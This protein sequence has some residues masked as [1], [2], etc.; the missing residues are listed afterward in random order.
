M[1][2]C[3]ATIQK[4]TSSARRYALLPLMLGMIAGNCYAPEAQATPTGGVVSHGEATIEAISDNTTHITQNSQSAIIDWQ[5]FDLSTSDLVHFDQPSASAAVLNRIHDTNPSQI[6]GAIEGNGQVFLINP[7]GILIGAGAEV[8]VGSLFLSTMDISDDD[9]MQGNYQ[10]S[11]QGE[12]HGSIINQGVIEASTGG[13]VAMVGNTV[14]N[15]GLIM[16]DVGSVHLLAGNAITVDFDGDGL[17]QFQIDEGVLSN[18]TSAEAAV[19]NTGIIMAPGGQVVMSAEVASSIFTHAVNNSGIIEAENVNNQAGRI[20]LEGYGA[21]IVNSGTL[22]VDGILGNAG[23]I[24]M[25]SDAATEVVAYA[26]MSARSIGEDV[27]G[28][29]HILGDE[30]ALFDHVLLDAS[31]QHG[32]GEILIGGD[33]QGQ[34]EVPN[35]QYTYVDVDVDIKADAIYAGN[36]GKVIVWADDS[37]YIHGNIYAQGGS[38]AGNGGF[39]ETSGKQYLAVSKTPLLT[40]AHGTGGTWLLDPNNIEI[41][42]GGGNTNINAAHPFVSTDDTAQL[43]VDLILSALTGG[44]TVT[45]TTG[46]GGADSQ[47]GDITLSTDID[48]DGKGSN[49]LSLIAAND[50]IINADIKDSVNDSDQLTVNLTADNDITFA[51]SVDILSRGGNITVTADADNT[52]GGA[53]TMTNGALLYSL[54]GKIT[55]QAEDDITIGGLKSDSSASDAISVTSDSGAIIDAGDFDVELTA[56]AGSGGV[57]LDAATGIGTSLN[58]IELFVGSVDA[59]NRTSGDI[60]LHQT[61]SINVV[62]LDQ[63]ATGSDIVSLTAV[64]SGDINILSSGSGITSAATGMITLNAGDDIIVDNDITAATGGSIDIDATGDFSIVATKKIVGGGNGTTLTIDAGGT[65]IVINNTTGGAIRQTGTGTIS[66]TGTGSGDDISLANN[67]ISAGTGLVALTAVGDE[68]IGDTSGTAEISAGGSVSLTATTMGTAVN[69]IEITG[70][71]TGTLTVSSDAS[72]AEDVHIDVLVDKFTALSITLDDVDS[73]VSI[74]LPG[75]DVVTITGG[76]LLSVLTNIVLTNT[77]PTFTYTLNDSKG[78]QIDNVDLGASAFTVQTTNGDLLLSSATGGIVASGAANIILTAAGAG[79]AMA[80]DD[81]ITTSGTLTLTSVDGI[82]GTANISSDGISVIDADSDNDGT[83]NFTL[84]AGD[85]LNTSD[86]NLTLTA[87]DITLNGN[88]N[89]GSGSLTILVSHSSTMGLGASSGGLS[90][91]DAELDNI[92]TSGTLTIGDSTTTTMSINGWTAAAGISG[93]VVLTATGAGGAITFETAASTFQAGLTLNALDGVTFNESVT[94]AGVTVIDADSNDDG[95]GDFTIA[96]AKTLTTTNSNLTISADDM[97]LTGSINVGS[98]DISLL[99]SNSTTVGLGAGAGDF[100]L[101]DAELNT[102]TTSGT[103]TIGNANATVMTIDAWSVA[104]TITGDVVLTATGTAGTVTLNNAALTVPA[105]LTITALD[106]VTLNQDVTSVGVTVIDADSDDNGTGD[107]TVAAA[108]TLTTT[109]NSLTLTANDII[110]TGNINTGSAATTLLVSD[111]GTIGLGATA[112]NYTLEGAELQ[113]ITA[114]G[115][116]LGDATNGSVTVNGITAANSNNV[117]GTLTLNATL[118]NASLTFATAA[119][120]FN[121]LTVNGDQGI[122]ISVDLTTDV[123]AMTLEGDADNAADTNDYISIAGGVTLTSATSITLDATTGGIL[124]DA[125]VT[126]NANNGI[127]INDDITTQASGAVTIDADVDANGSGDFTLAATKTL[128]SSAGA[129]DTVSITADGLV[130]DGSINAGTG[131]VSL[132]PSNSSTVGLGAGAGDFSL[133][134]A[135]LDG[136]TTSGILTIGNSNATIMIIDAWSV[137]G[138]ITGDVVLAATG[139]AGTVTLNGAALTLASALTISATDGVIFNQ[140]VTSAGVTVID[141]DANDNGAGDFTMASTKTLTTTNN[142]LTLTAN[143][144]TLTG[145]VDTGSAAITLLVSD[146]GTI[147]LGATAGDYTLT[148]AELQNI[149]ATGLTLGDVNN[150]S[151]T[152][153]GITAANSNNVSGVF[154]L[155]ATADNANVSFSTAASTFNA[156]TVNADDGLTINV[157]LTTDTGALVLEGDADGAADASDNIIIASGLTLTAE[158]SMTLDATTGGIAPADSVTLQAK[159]GITIND[160]F[161]LTASGSVIIDADTDANGTGDFILASG[162]TLNSNGG[163]IDITADNIVLGSG[164]SINAGAGNISLNPSNST[165]VGLGAGTGDFSLT[166]DELDGFTLSGTLTIGNGN[167]TTMTIDGWTAVAGISGLVILLATGA[168][169]SITFNNN[170]SSYQAGLTLTALAGVVINKDVNSNGVTTVDADF[171]DNGVGAFTVADFLQTFDTGNNALTITADDIVITG[172]IDAG[173]GAVSLLPSSSTTVGL[174]AGAGDFSLTDAELDNITTSGI[175]TIGNSNATTM[176]IDTWSVAGIITGNV[177]LTATGALGSITLNGAALTVSSALIITALDGVTFNQNVSSAGATVIDA[178]SNDDG[179][180]DFTLAAAQTLTTSNNTLTLTANDITLDGNISTGSA[181]ITLL[182][183]DAGAIGLGATAGDY[184]LSSAELQNITSTG[185]TLGDATNGSVTVN[186]ITAANSNNVS[187]TLTLNATLDNA[188]VTFATTAST[189]NTLTINADQGITIGVDLTTDV[190]AMTLEGDADNAADTNDFI[191]I[192]AGVTLTSADSVTLDATTGGILADA[193]VTINADN[194]VTI[195]DNFTTQASGAVIIDADVDANGSG[196]FTLAATKT[197][198]SSAG[199]VDSV[200]ITADDIILSGSISADT[201]NVSLLPSNSTTV[202]LGDGAGDFSLTDTELDNIT[203]SGTLTI[204][205]SNTTTMTVNGWTAAVGLSGSVVLTATGTAGTITFA[206]VASTLQAALTLTALDGVTLN[207]SVTSNGATVIDADS[208]DNG[209]GDFTIAAAKT[210]T[211]TNNNLTITAN[212]MVLSGSITAGSGDVSLLPSSSTTVGLGAGAGDFFL[213]DA[214]LDGITTSGTFTIGNSNATVMIIDAWSVA[215]TITGDV[216]LTATGALGT[217]TLNSAAL[218]VAAAL[219]ITALDGVAF[220]QSVTSVGATVIDADSDG[221]GTGDFTIAAAKILTTTNNTLTLTANDI[222]LTGSVNTGSAA[223][224][225]LV[226]DAGAIGLG[227]TAGDYTLSGAE[228]QNITSTGL[229]LGDAT[230]GSI[231]VN[232]ITAAN[233]NNVSGTVTLNAT[234]DNASVTF[235]TTASTF[236]ALTANADDG[237]VIDVALTTDVGA[238]TLEGDA[239][240]G[241]DTNDNITIATGLTLISAD[242]I[243]LDATTSGIA[244]ADAVTFNADNG[245]TINDSLTTVASG[246]VTIDADADANGSGDFTLAA[247]ATLNSSSG[248][249]DTLSITADDIVLTGSINAGTGDVSLLPSNNTTVG[250]GAGAGDFSLTD[251]ELDGITTSGILTIGNTNTTTMLIDTWTVAGT[252]TG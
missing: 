193:A 192:A 215:G 106:G 161:S 108:K 154:T 115:L 118:D 191:S 175:L 103:L 141:A 128:N 92:T 136:V 41:V 35:A 53:I 84:T 121:T 101:T 248:A 47:S 169:G 213:T 139:T 49:T 94:S 159:N 242:S 225:L 8:N 239:D 229:T 23:D 198:N 46:T 167:A 2:N 221:N 79:S 178:D 166:D 250:L 99:P 50:I 122:T 224:T 217:V 227:A 82:D 219:T 14:S 59:H 71:G 60:A 48:F 55:L 130:L 241:V 64:A 42:A 238:M 247:G 209:T 114:T 3:S 176:I 168:G 165:T 20:K 109:N 133:A 24:L 235:A 22:S 129:I 218:T 98:G 19:S 252:I 111:A 56:F 21:G 142:I 61:T 6:F 78:I 86:N 9:F 81:V 222:T 66:L 148:G 63:D 34:G 52:G 95:T 125:A 105:A 40:A 90:L 37:A 171:D 74:E 160:N 104:G 12:A 249:V 120:I 91:T 76:A 144:V 124:P 223:T 88:I 155:N 231:T 185:L 138:T 68:I 4:I 5:T 134:D 36:G 197:L 15:E 58:S 97:S 13:F 204:G 135:E 236:N 170:A 201:G 87:N 156:L 80:L 32:G 127:T 51:G 181:A 179:T 126:I 153:D 145:N 119:S 158:T 110:V 199:A 89:T 172:S 43:G 96:A 203:T 149:T 45:I 243:T 117:S 73:D 245:V 83:G 57:I 232:G 205:N 7:N 189:F 77:N 17:I 183:S 44:A 208:D 230:N 228:L 251:T 70:S 180:G 212:D 33:Y 67:S 195:N 75:V 210:L 112:G 29:I 190:G 246:A 184:T 233:S 150:G 147:G 131:D 28:T 10:F 54:T 194:G 164:S 123:G 1:K 163:S 186:G 206:T 182:V 26:V 234:L 173:T 220:N 39:V 85:T 196:N 65:G 132:L 30:V 200:S 237:I 188:S 62:K 11:S 162:K 152:V 226:S 177:V 100:S 174:G 38:V 207:E 211:T 187:G 146:A 137:A 16:A 116:T 244:P 157:A 27:G 113:N 240:N 18:A 93:P 202:G 69:P 72:A 140:S 143:D 216:I 102:I 107:F 151:I 214:E 31:G 25:I